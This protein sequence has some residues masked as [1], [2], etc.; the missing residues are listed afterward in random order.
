MRKILLC[1]L[2][3]ISVFLTGC[4]SPYQKIGYGGGYYH[5]RIKEDAYKVVFRGNGFTERNRAYDFA[6]LRAAEICIQ[7]G[8]THFVVEGEEHKTKTTNID[9]GSTSYTSGSMYGDSSF[10]G[11]TE[12][13]SNSMPV[14]KPRVELFVRYF[15][16]V[17]SGRYLE[18]HEAEKVIQELSSKYNIKIK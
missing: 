15:E 10:Y 17:P 5:Q 3:C 6:L 14:S 1:L 16:S 8:Y 9:M 18:I 12:T 13:Y 7:L 11:T 4:A 2:F